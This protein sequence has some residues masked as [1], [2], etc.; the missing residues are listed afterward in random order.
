MMDGKT[1]ST[2]IEERAADWAV[3][4]DAGPPS[5]EDE[6]RLRAW[7]A[8]DC[9]CEGA[10]LRARAVLH[11]AHRAKALGTGFDRLNLLP[12]SSLTTPAPPEPF[13]ID[14]R[15]A[16]LRV[17]LG[18]RALLGLGCLLAAGAVISPFIDPGSRAEAAVLRTSIGETRRVELADG[19]AITLNTASE[20]RLTVHDDRREI[21]LVAG[22]ALFHIPPGAQRCEVDAGLFEV[23]C[24]SAQFYLR[25]IDNEPVSLTV[26]AG[27][28]KMVL[29]TSA[30]VLAGPRMR[31]SIGADGR[32]DVERL[33]ERTMGRDLSWRYGKLMFDS[34][35]LGAA[36]RMFARYSDQHIHID[37]PSIARLK[38]TGVFSATQPL[39]FASA[40]AGMFSLGMVGRNGG[41]LL[42][43]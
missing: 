21:V 15:G 41:V 33:S 36:A 29:P 16:P 40:V 39:K 18:R 28:V 2:A 32:A 3:L 8:A 31:L 6:A 43:K 7:L 5:S 24:E 23:Q 26:Q 38:V 12:S 20:V 4:L 30:P 35:E 13:I 25:R 34:T 9:R 37:D 17:E 27:V 42:K 11:V 10:L 14:E 1:V 22:E 19:L